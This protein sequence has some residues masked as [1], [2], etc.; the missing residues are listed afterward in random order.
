M[1]YLTLEKTR[2]VARIWFDDP[3]EKMNVIKPAMMEEL[4]QTLDQI[5]S[6]S[7]LRAVV[8]ISA[9]EGCFIAGADINMFAEMPG[10]EEAIARARE[11]H[12][13]LTRLAEMRIPTVA[14]V[15]GVCLGGGL[16]V[17]L[18]CQYRI[19][20]EDAETSFG[21][22]E[23]KLGLL[24]GLG[25]TQRLPRLIG[26][27]AALDLLLTGKNLYPR[28]AR[29]LGLIDE[30]VQPHALAE[31]AIR[32]A[33]D[34][35]HRKRKRKLA[36][37]F[38]ESPLGRGLVFSQAA[39]RVQKQTAGNYPAPFEI[40]KCVRTGMSKGLAVGIETEIAAFDRL[41]RT[42]ESKNLVRLFF[43]MN[44][45]RKN[46]HADKAVPVKNL[47]ILGAGLMG[48]G[49]AEVSAPK[50]YRVFLKD[51]D[52]GAL[53]RGEKMIGKAY[54][55]KVKRKIW[56]PFERDRIFSM[57]H[58]VTDD[59]SLA[60]CDLVIEAVF[61]DLALKR[62][63]LEAVE[64]Q[65]PEHAVFASNTSSIPIAQIAEAAK[66]PEQVIGMHYFSP[67][68]KMPLL[69][70]VVT[71]RT[72][73]QAL[74]TAV[75]V[76]I[77][78]GKHIIVVKDGP[79]FYT[80]R[81]LGPMLNEAVLLLREGASVEDIDRAM[82]RFGF[83]VGPVKLMDEVGID[84]GAHVGDVFAPMMA[85]RGVQPDD[86]LKR[87]VAAG[88]AGRK[89]GKGFYVYDDGK[90]KG[91]NSEV[92]RFFG[93]ADRKTIDPDHIVER[94]SLAFCNE[95]VWC[96]QEKII[97][98]PADGDLGAILGLGFPPFRGGPFRHLDTLGPA[99]A[100]ARLEALADS[101]GPRFK[102]APL[103]ADYRDRSFHAD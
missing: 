43:G 93:G 59:A 46:P 68:A 8:L 38:L 45:S 90:A 73:E 87:M 60:R 54:H 102:P 91:I 78:Q 2:D 52:A 72:S 99:E 79:G 58:G 92:Y 47:G 33:R 77:E 83:P 74:A 37:R 86:T 44:A 30:L 56:T 100:H 96:L 25:G 98:K 9:K 50:G 63:V 5:E 85:D 48:A 88:Y 49:I 101:L 18:A 103:L 80:T 19:A 6:D 29:K 3:D 53:G 24:P 14:A 84:V 13:L 94:L 66:R 16:E 15:R 51:L 20:A 61:E 4:S 82:F 23:V 27:T 65:L 10:S 12:A 71:D 1:K 21:L 11:G 7:S 39:K 97:A 57:I 41:V 28:K 42:E 62:R 76:G 31:A 69:E 32:F 35:K 95:A 70:I 67:V 26:L 55:K 36:V 22:P 64:A 40:L 75:E 89:N 17:A 81:V 34:P